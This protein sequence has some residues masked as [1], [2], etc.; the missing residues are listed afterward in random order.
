MTTSSGAEP[1]VRCDDVVA[2]FTSSQEPTIALQ[3]VNLSVA[4][5]ETLAITGPSGSGKSTLL[6]VMLGSLAP[7]AGSVRLLGRP[8]SGFRRDRIRKIGTT[9]QL[10][11]QNLLLTATV[12]QNLR[13]VRNAA[14]L[15]K[16]EATIRELLDGLR[17][18]HV[19]EAS[20]M[21]LSG[22]EQQRLA[23]AIALVTEPELVLTDEPTSQQ[24]R[25]TAELVVAQ[26]LAASRERGATVVAV[27]HDDVLAS[28]MS[29]AVTIRDGVLGSETRAG[30]RVVLVREDGTIQLPQSVLDG[31]LPVG[32][33]VELTATDS[34]AVIRRIEPG[35]DDV[36]D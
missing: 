7:T 10:P 19:A 11:A 1:A 34:G 32:S 18:T 24:D 29:R 6:A 13:I 36:A 21:T 33:A 2:V 5:G 9:L 12:E 16:D 28:S 25:A 3:R 22:G 14:R 8:P 30:R 15:P 26:L 27:T 31:P 35:D 4:R 23:V 17:L 20:A